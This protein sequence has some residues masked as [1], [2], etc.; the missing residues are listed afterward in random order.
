MTPKEVMQAIIDGKTLTH[1]NGSCYLKL[2]EDG[3]VAYSSTS[4][5]GPFYK[6]SSL[7]VVG[8]KEHKVLTF[9]N[10]SSNCRF[11]FLPNSNHMKR[12]DIDFIKVAISKYSYGIFSPDYCIVH[13]VGDGFS[14]DS[15]VVQVD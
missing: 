1:E 6:Q 13:H 5:K 4:L 3:D 9:K 8:L 11:R 10:L 12:L 2:D 7:P 15:P 14:E